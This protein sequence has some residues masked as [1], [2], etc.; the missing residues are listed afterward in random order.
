MPL[1]PQTFAP[2][3]E[4]LTKLTYLLL[5]R[6]CDDHDAVVVPRDLLLSHIARWSLIDNPAG[7]L[8][9]LRR[10]KVVVELNDGRVRVR[11]PK[12]DLKSLPGSLPHNWLLLLRGTTATL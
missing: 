10:N 8:D 11:R 2:T 6:L 1:P 7:T 3:P 5:C 4:P 12:R 9:H